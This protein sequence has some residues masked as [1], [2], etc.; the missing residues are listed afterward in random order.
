MDISAFQSAAE[1]LQAQNI[2]AIRMGKVVGQPVDLPNCVDYASKYHKDLMDLYLCGNCKFYA[3]SL[4]GITAFAQLQNRPTVLLGLVQIGIHNAIP[5]R[6]S[7]IYVPKKI[8]D[9]KK[10]R[11]LNFREMWDAEMAAKDQV[12]QYYLAQELEFIELEES[13]VRD[14]IVEMNERIDGTYQEDSYEKELQKKYHQ[15]LEHRIEQ[16]HYHSSY[17]QQINISGSFIKQNAFMLE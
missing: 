1:Y 12:S 6:S 17:F 13:Q 10:K 4:S 2:K 8:Y 3:G 5:Y 14:A 16:H 15:L 9:K 7:D 11:I